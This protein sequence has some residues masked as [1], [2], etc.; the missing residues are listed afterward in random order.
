[1]VLL[2]FFAETWADVLVGKLTAQVLFW[3]CCRKLEVASLTWESL[4]LI[5]QEV[6]F[7][8]VGKHGVERYFL[9]PERLFEQ[10]VSAGSSASQFVFAALL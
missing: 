8:I 5:R 9:I 4:R 3:S 1:M 10:L 6:H 2:T 7:E